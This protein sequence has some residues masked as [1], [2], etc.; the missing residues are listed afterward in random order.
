MTRSANRRVKIRDLIEFNDWLHVISD[1][2][3]VRVYA[4]SDSEEKDLFRAELVE[5]LRNTMGLTLTCSRDSHTLSRNHVNVS[6]STMSHV[7]YSLG[8]RFCRVSIFGMKWQISEAEPIL[9][10]FI[11]RYRATMVFLSFCRRMSLIIVLV[12]RH[13]IWYCI[14]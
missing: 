12:L 9:D 5:R 8:A 14:G 1:L 13:M 7:F 6:V 11:E 4:G 10:R 2:V 3:I